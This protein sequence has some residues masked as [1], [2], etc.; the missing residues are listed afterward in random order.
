MY[1]SIILPVIHLIIYILIWGQFIVLLKHQQNPPK[2]KI[3]K[4]Q[5]YP[6]TT[7]I[8]YPSFNRF[9][10]ANCKLDYTQDGMPVSAKPPHCHSFALLLTNNCTCFLVFLACTSLDLYFSCKLFGAWEIFYG[11]CC[12]VLNAFGS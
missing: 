4:P 9:L 6:G 7:S 12:T 3:K 11:L 1:N 5:R 8:P 2:I 10:S